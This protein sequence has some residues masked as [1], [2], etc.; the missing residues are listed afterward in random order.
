M[1]GDSELIAKQVL[2]LY[3]VKHAAMRPLHLRGA[4]ALRG[5]AAGRSAPSRARRTPT[6]TRSS[7]KPSTT[8]G[9]GPPSP[10]LDEG[11]RDLARAPG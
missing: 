8:R 9:S 6:P 3:K 1:I 11:P 2:G 4:D 5:F 7:T 10:A